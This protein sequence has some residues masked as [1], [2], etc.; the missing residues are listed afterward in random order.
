MD[1][2]NYHHVD[3]LAGQAKALGKLVVAGGM[4]PSLSYED[5][6]DHTNNVDYIVCGEGE[7]PLE[8]L[9]HAL[10]VYGSIEAI[11]SSSY[12]ATRRN[13]TKPK[14]WCKNTSL[15]VDIV[16]DFYQGKNDVLGL[17]YTTMI[18][19]NECSHHCTFCMSHKANHDFQFRTAQSIVERIEAKCNH[20]PI[21]H[22]YFTDNDIFDG[23]Y[24]LQGYEKVAEILDAIEKS[25]LIGLSYNCGTRVDAVCFQPEHS[26]ILGRMRDIG[27]AHFFLGVESG[28]DKDLKLYGKGVNVA[29]SLTAVETLQKNDIYPCLGFIMINPYSDLERLSQNHKFLQKSL[30]VS[31]ASYAGGQLMVEKCNPFYRMALRDGIFEADYSFISPYRYRFVHQEIKTINDFLIETF[32]QDTHFGGSFDPVHDLHRYYFV[33]KRQYPELRRYGQAVSSLRDRFL[34]AADKF[35]GPLYLT[36]NI[37]EARDRLEMFRQELQEMQANCLRVRKSLFMDMSRLQLQCHK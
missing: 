30:C 4:F 31:L 37:E 10:F 18:K 7:R 1:R 22:V 28:N 33:M 12:I 23:N 24:P 17:E 16:D 20:T 29:Q 8:D 32:G 25:D 36:G 5:V 14:G 3:R 26:R 6:F 19:P 11:E 15:D 27:F 2:I 34:E 21:S 9:L 13:F 35:F